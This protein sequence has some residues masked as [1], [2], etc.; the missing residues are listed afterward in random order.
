MDNSS[1]IKEKREL[2][3]SRAGLILAMAGNAIGLGNFLR[4]PVQAAENGGGAFMVPYIIAFFLLGIPLMWVEWA[5][6]R[7][8]GSKGHGTAPAI[9]GIFWNSRLSR[10]LGVFGL[11]IPLVVAIYYIYIE[12]WSLGYAINFLFGYTPSIQPDSVANTTEYMK[13][14]SAFLSNYIGAGEGTFL[15]PSV[16]AFVAFGITAGL[17]LYILKRGISGGIEV[18]AKIA[19]P[20][21]FIIAVLL[22]LRVLTLE[23]P[24]GNAFDGLN[25]LWT[26]DFS[27]LTQPS[28]WIAAAGQ[29]FFT[30][31]LGFGA[32]ITYASYIKYDNDITL[33]GLTSATLNETAEIVLGGSIAIPAAVAF[34]GVSGAITIA[35]SGAF[36]LGFVSLPAIFASMPGSVLGIES[37][38]IL[39]FLWFFLLF[40]AGVTSSVAITQPVIAFFEDE[41]GYTRKKSVIITMSIIIV[42]VMMVIFVNKTLDEWDFWAGTIAVVIFGL[43]ELVMFMWI[44]GGD[45][46]WNELNRSG[47]IKVPRFFYYVMRYVTPLFLIFIIAW[48]GYEQL[49]AKL[50]ESGWNVWVARLYL[51]GLFIFLCILTFIS[52]SYGGDEQNGD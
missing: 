22:L 47:I 49:P 27:A 42:S 34:F 4:F 15:T 14:F 10:L 41:F 23:T 11:W 29:I 45:R 1:G 21:L 46:A 40:F 2:W 32:I 43:V 28:V 36:D 17:N 13:P 19:L 52:R 44:F 33:S 12:S 20:T 16:M 48:W 26:P 30:L 31:S 9:F 51:V 8:G 18:F 5:I 25:F 3:A 7:Y 38:R 50:L 39:G 6:G 24:H 37:G 35:H